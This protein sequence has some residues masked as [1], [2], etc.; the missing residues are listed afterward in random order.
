MGRL[1]LEFC[2]LSNIRCKPPTSTRYLAIRSIIVSHPQSTH[3]SLNKQNSTISSIPPKT[4]SPNVS[5]V[6]SKVFFSGGGKGLNCTVPLKQLAWELAGEKSTRAEISKAVN[7]LALRSDGTIFGDNTDGIG[8]INDFVQNLGVSLEGIRILILGAGGASRGIL[9]PF[10]R[11]TPEKPWSLQIE[12]YP[13][14]RNW[15]KNFR[16]SGLFLRATSKT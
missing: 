14:Q 7:T 3:Y 13:R 5:V 8:L 6:R 1:I 15:N 4:S 9:K 10:T 12:P 11:A 16:N 2:F